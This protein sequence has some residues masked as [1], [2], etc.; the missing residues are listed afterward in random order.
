MRFVSQHRHLAVLPLPDRCIQAKAKH[1]CGYDAEVKLKVLCAEV[2]LM[3]RGNITRWLSSETNKIGLSKGR[4]C[5]K[6][7]A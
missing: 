3:G 6:S 2:V 5:L 4:P 1:R 7:E